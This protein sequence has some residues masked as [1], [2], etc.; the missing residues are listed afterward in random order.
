MAAMP[1][2]VPLETPAIDQAMLLLSA[3]GSD[4]P[5]GQTSLLECGLA[6]LFGAIALHQ[7]GQGHPWLEL[8]V[9]GMIV[10]SI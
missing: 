6:L 7:L 10:Y 9:I 3:A 2:L 4:E 5:F 8:D 1:T